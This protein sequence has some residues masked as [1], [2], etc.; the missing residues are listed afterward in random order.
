M[1]D[2]NPE[3]LVLAA[4]MAYVIDQELAVREKARRA[5]QERRAATE[6]LR[7]KGEQLQIMADAL[8]VLIAYIDADGRYQFNNA[9]YEHW[10]GVPRHTC[11]GRHVREV[12]GEHAYRAIENHVIAALAGLPQSFEVAIPYAAVGLRHVHASYV[13]H[14]GP[15]RKVAGFYALIVDITERK[16]LEREVLG[17]RRLGADGASARSCTTASARN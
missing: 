14:C 13:P 7:L 5:E 17:D 9:A 3:R 1:A 11:Q 10:F 12:L 6:A 15:D 4:H 2:G 8:P 16:E